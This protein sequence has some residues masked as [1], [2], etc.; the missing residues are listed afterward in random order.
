MSIFHNQNICKTNFIIN[1]LNSNS[2]YL[3][4]DEV[5]DYQQ[6]LNDA[7]RVFFATSIYEYIQN[8]GRFIDEALFLATRHAEKP[9]KG[10]D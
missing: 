7:A 6:R 5:E 2:L 9:F 3:K 4:E 10:W 8:N 1:I